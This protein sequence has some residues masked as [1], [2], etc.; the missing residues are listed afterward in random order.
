MGDVVG[1]SPVEVE[2]GD[3]IATLRRKCQGTSIAG[4]LDVVERLEKRS[5]VRHPQGASDGSTFFRMGAFL[6]ALVDKILS[7]GS[8]THYS[9]RP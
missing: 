5:L 1:W 7:S 3:D 2:L 4:Y 6:R 9:S 8:Y